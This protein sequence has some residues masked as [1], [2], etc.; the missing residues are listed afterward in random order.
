MTT[1]KILTLQEDQHRNDTKK[2]GKNT[3]LKAA[4]NILKNSKKLF[5]ESEYQY[6]RNTED[7]Q[8]IMDGREMVLLKESDK[9]PLEPMPENIKAEFDY[10]KVIPHDYTEEL[11]L[12]D[13]KKLKA[14]LKIKKAQ[15][16]KERFY[17][18]DFGENYPLVNAAYLINVMEIIKTDIC[19]YKSA[20]SPILLENSN[21]SIGMICPVRKN[22]NGLDEEA[23]ITAEDLK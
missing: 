9:L 20:L 14:A 22:P 1:E 4:K 12:P 8:L 13:I 23:T 10:K 21:G 6:A 5:L 11:I 18:F 17:F 7:G 3:A 16:P 19:K 2:S 15:N